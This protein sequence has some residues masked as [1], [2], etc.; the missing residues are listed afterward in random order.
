VLQVV[1]E[2]GDGD[3]EALAGAEPP[4]Q[5]ALQSQ[6][7]ARLPTP[8]PAQATAATPS[9]TAAPTAATDAHPDPTN[10]RV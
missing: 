3:G 6:N 8:T 9:T 5:P 1:A 7:V 2:A 4:Q 10:R